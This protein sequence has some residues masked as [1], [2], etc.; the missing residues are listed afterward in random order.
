[1]VFIAVF[2]NGFKDSFL[3]SLDRSITSD[4]IIQNDDFATIPAGAVTAATQAPG[5]DVVTGLAFSEVKIGNGGRD[6]VN[7]I[8]PDTITRVYSFN[9]QKGTTDQAALNLGN[10]DALVEEQFA[11]SH[12]LAK[13][14]T[15]TITSVDNVRA[16][17][18]VKGQ[19]KDPTLMAGFTVSNA[20]FDTFADTADPSV[21]L[22]G[23][24]DGVGAEQGKQSVKDALKGFP[25]AT[26]RTNSEYK[27]F[28]EDQVN[29]FLGFL[30]VLLG[31][32]VVIS[33]F[34][35]VNTLALSVFERTREI[36]ML[37]AVGMTRRQLRRVVRY[38]SIITAVIGG[39]L[40]IVV[41]LAF[42]WILSKGLEDQGIVF[43]VP[44]GL[45]FVVVVAA[46]IAGILAAIL[47]A[48][49]ASRLN[50]LEALQYEYRCPPSV[51]RR[52]LTPLSHASG[53]AA[54]RSTGGASAA[55]NRGSLRGRTK[56]GVPASMPSTSASS[57]VSWAVRELPS[58]SS[59]ETRTSKPRCTSRSTTAGCVVPFGLCR[60]SR[61]C[62]RTRAPWMRLTGPT[63]LITKLL[64][65]CS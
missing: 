38:E 15:F 14:D 19:Y 52:G 4:L 6:F 27:S 36:G 44:Y 33:L 25:V 55:A 45:L 16:T 42:G 53:A 48:R 7:G 58:S 35:I 65:G 40:G 26:V 1:V 10:D 12:D 43:S 8:D 32:A 20:T 47:P 46:V 22:V 24:D 18:T 61:S 49:R 23:L 59:S 63:K 13:G 54:S 30:Y 37:R 56:T 57:R 50:V 41:G 64:T 21:I 3:G 9:W 62:G 11:K 2:V 39:I 29:G 60:I 28:T 34:G 51:R 17:L 5:V 31:M